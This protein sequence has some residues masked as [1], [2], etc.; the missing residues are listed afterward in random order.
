MII[1]TGLQ[2]KRALVTGSVQGIGLAIARELARCGV[3]V[4]LH[5]LPQPDVH[6]AALSAV[7]AAGGGRR[8]HCHTTCQT[9]RWW[10]E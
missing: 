1:G 8:G 3:D 10:S 6:A 7:E 2:G 5:G 9:A 4:V